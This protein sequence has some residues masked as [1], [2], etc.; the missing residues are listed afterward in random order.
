MELLES[1]NP[2]MVIFTLGITLCLTIAFSA[3]YFW[4]QSALTIEEIDKKLI[5]WEET[6]PSNYSYVVESGC[7]FASTSQVFVLNGEITTSP[8]SYQSNILIENLFPRIK[9]LITTTHKLQV[10]FDDQ[11]HYPKHINID[12]HESGLHDECFISISDFIHIN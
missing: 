8:T 5:L 6:K 11:Y 2:Y 3:L 4:K 10:D 12:Y 7:M 9:E 1:K